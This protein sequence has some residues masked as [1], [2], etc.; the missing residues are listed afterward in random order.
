MLGIP[1]HCRS[2][3]HIPS[4]GYRSGHELLLDTAFEE[5]L[6]NI[7]HIATKRFDGPQ[8]VAIWVVEEKA[9]LDLAKGTLRPWVICRRNA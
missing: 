8:T 7:S 1:V 6:E 3:V 2:V 9:P 5:S 4:V